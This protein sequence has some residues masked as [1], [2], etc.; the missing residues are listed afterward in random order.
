M[1]GDHSFMQGVL[2][3]I[4]VLDVFGDSVVE[5]IRC[6]LGMPIAFILYIDCNAWIEERKFSKALGEDIELEISGFFKDFRVWHER[7]FRACFF[8][9]TDYLYFLSC[10]TLSELHLVD[11][12]VPSHLS[13]KPF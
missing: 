1:E 10:N 4:E 9:V 11:F 13:L 8:C 2:A 6:F 5:L 12:A 3:P 7:D